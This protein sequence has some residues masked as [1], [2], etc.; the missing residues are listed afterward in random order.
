MR[1]AERFGS[2]KKEKKKVLNIIHKINDNNSSNYIL[3]TSNILIHNAN[4]NEANTSA[5]ITLLSK[6]LL[7]IGT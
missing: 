5:K 4:F 7:A 1:V 3:S 6:T 2:K